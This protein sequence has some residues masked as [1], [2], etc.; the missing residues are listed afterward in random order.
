MT[1]FVVVLLAAA[2]A[3]TV[4]SQRVL[5]GVEQIGN[6]VWTTSNGVT[7]ICRGRQRSSDRPSLTAELQLSAVLDSVCRYLESRASKVISTVAN[8]DSNQ[9]TDQDIIADIYQSVR[10]DDQ[11]Q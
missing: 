1:K 5:A 3:V 11:E 4:G 9:E 8:P 2:A 7:V 10:Y 6:R